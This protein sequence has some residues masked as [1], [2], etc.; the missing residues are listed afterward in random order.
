MI[1]VTLGYDTF[2]C[3][4][5]SAAITLTKKMKMNLKFTALSLMFWNCSGHITSDKSLQNLNDSLLAAA[6]TRVSVH[7][8]WL[9]S[10]SDISKTL[11]S[12]HN[13]NQSVFLKT[14]NRTEFPPL[15]VADINTEIIK[16]NSLLKK[17]ETEI[18]ALNIKLKDAGI[19]NKILEDSV[20][21]LNTRLIEKQAELMDLYQ[22]VSG[23]D[24]D[25]S[26]LQAALYTLY[27]QNA[28]QNTTIIKDIHEAN[29][30]NYVIGPT[31]ELEQKNILTKKNNSINNDL[32]PSVFNKIDIREKKDFVINR[33]HAKLLTLHSTNS[34][35]FEKDK[36]NISRL[37]ITDPAEF[38]R[39]SKFLVIKTD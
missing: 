16:I 9:S 33:K 20:L 17:N 36:K 7:S 28:F 15:L 24:E 19:L 23:L 4:Q 39:I 14:K 13:K 29:A 32:D 25:I 18:K 30:A 37:I 5:T 12:I 6:T 26:D 27:V 1:W 38:W 35:K 21:H 31:K 10:I 34:Y 2:H 8:E 3:Y 11:D 22:L